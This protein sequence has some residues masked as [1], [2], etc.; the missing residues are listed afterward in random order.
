MNKNN[1]PKPIHIG[2]RQCD[3]FPSA[4]SKDYVKIDERSFN[5]LIQQMSEY[6][7]KV[8]FYNDDNPDK[9]DGH[10]EPFFKEIYDYETQSIKL[11]TLQKQM[12][13][14]TVPPHLSLLLSFL[15]LYQIEQNNLNRLTERHLEFY[16]KKVLGFTPRV[17]KV[18]NA[19]V[20]VSPVKN[21]SSVIIPKGT[22]FDAGKDSKGKTIL[23]ESTD[24][25]TINKAQV[26]DCYYSHRFDNGN[27]DIETL[28][29]Q[30]RTQD[31]VETNSNDT[32]QETIN[33]NFG[34]AIAISSFLE[35]KNQ[36]YINLGTLGEEI[37]L[38]FFTI[39]YT[40]LKGW[41]KIEDKPYA[42]IKEL[43][44][45]EREEFNALIDEI[46][47]DLN[48][49]N[50]H[51][52][53]TNS[54]IE[55]FL[56]HEDP[57]NDL[58][59]KISNAT[60]A[61]GNN[62]RERR[63]YFLKI[64]G[65]N[66]PMVPYNP[67]LHGEGYNS[68]NP[69]IR[70]LPAKG[71]DSRYID[72]QKNEIWRVLNIKHDSFNNIYLHEYESTDNITIENIYGMVNNVAGISPFGYI[73]QKNDYFLVKINI[74][75]REYY[76]NLKDDTYTIN[77]NIDGFLP[78]KTKYLSNTEYPVIQYTLK[79]DDRRIDKRMN[80]Y[81]NPIEETEGYD[82]CEECETVPTFDVT[83]ESASENDLH[84][85]GLIKGLKGL[86]SNV[87][88]NIIEKT[89]ITVL[90]NSVEANAMYIKSAFEAYGATVEI[91][92][93]SETTR[94]ETRRTAS[95]SKIV[96]SRTESSLNVKLTSVG[97]NKLDVIKKIKEIS[98]LGLKEAK[99][100]VENVPSI[101]KENVDIVTA[102]ALKKQLE[103]VGATV[104]ITDKPETAETKK[105]F[106]VFLISAG[107]NKL[108][109]IKL[110]REF[111]GL[112]LGE[113]KVLVE[114]NAPAIIKENVN[115]ATAEDIKK[116][117]EEAGATVEIIGNSE[118]DTT[119]ENLTGTS[120]NIILKSAGASSLQI[121]KLIKNLNGLPLKEAKNLVESAP[122]IIKENVDR[123]TAEDI[124]KQL[125][126]AGATVELV[127]NS[128]TDTTLEN[129][130]GSD[131]N[132]ILKSVGANKVQIIKIIR[133]FVDLGLKE[134]KELVESAPCTIMSDV[135][136]KTVVNIKKQLEDAGAIV[137]ITGY[138]ETVETKT[139][140]NV[141]LKS[142]NE[143]TI[144]LI[145]II[146]NYTGLEWEESIEAILKA[147][148]PI[149]TGVEE[150]IAMTIINEFENVGAIATKTEISPTIEDKPDPN[151]PYTT[152]ELKKA[153]SYN[154]NILIPT[155]KMELFTIAPWG[156]NKIDPQDGNKSDSKESDDAANYIFQD[157]K[158]PPLKYVEG[159]EESGVFIAI[160]GISQP[161]CLNIYFELGSYNIN[162]QIIKWSYLS[163]EN[164]WKEFSRKNVCKDGTE[165]FSKNGIVQLYLNKEV[166]RIKDD[167]PADKIW[168]YVSTQKTDGQKDTKLDDFLHKIKYIQT[169]AVE[170]SFSEESVGTLQNEICLPQGS[171]TK[172]I[173]SITGIKKVEQPF[174]GFVGIASET[175]DEFNC[176]V[177]EKLRHKGKAW[178]SWDYERILLERF[179][180]L[181]AVR[182]VPC[183]SDDSGTVKI[184]V[185][186]NV[187]L[188]PQ[189]DIRKPQI[190]AFTKN[191]IEHYLKTLCSPFVNIEI[192]NPSYKEVD[193]T[194]KITLRKEYHDHTYYLKLI[195]EAL[196][197]YLAPWRSN[198]MNISLTTHTPKNLEIQYFLEKLEY[199]DFIKEL[200]VD[201]K[202][203]NEE[204]LTII[205]YNSI[206]ITID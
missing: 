196:T 141:I 86:G 123:E 146:H 20:F 37:N 8:N 172:L 157:A 181:A 180:Q 149:S 2:T 197:N 22:L 170:V 175:T 60:L 96:E 95:N 114:N 148:Y 66:N 161:T 54:N 1:T 75:R 111:S 43:S 30:S 152:F 183:S 33:L 155:Q 187:S 203:L 191:E 150:E 160:S 56:S 185:F 82:Q 176:R 39:E 14:G 168:L 151:N 98:G 122:T 55:K 59:R 101:I 78:E 192:L 12:N 117:L 85:I 79:N 139:S 137:E 164:K 51:E 16:Y 194:G 162:K 5:D 136:K 6:A 73:C 171:I 46:I 130:T 198:P 195:E 65:V 90:E 25:V 88:T 29:I 49:I 4:L 167:I 116:Q 36:K 91:T 26:N 184:V 199:V 205:T 94:T 89:P 189:G 115:I 27:Y 206:E 165:N 113:A 50:G 44:E 18:G 124:K 76:S 28:Q 163:A 144:Q 24:E 153:I 110:I 35:A 158:F 62:R 68:N 109:V 52:E 48:C 34:F 105:C 202:S 45:D 23:F 119:L 21:T 61:D 179:P 118:T 108:N 106:N 70:F 84:V 131:F 47:P 97:A 74:P 177:S 134:A 17:G 154:S 174:D 77:L 112:G 120:F 104:E 201:S 178:T 67:K 40:S 80:N 190:D 7:K 41:E 87:A 19:V 147:P 186:P 32:I 140:F 200:S 11:R 100:L 182:C 169:Q 193:I 125:E 102:E 93:N 10:W 173:K 9:A 107:A 42:C 126:T 64:D 38:E 63:H 135:D 81:L 188:I 13:E 132:V 83:L 142:V 99:E 69:I 143:N 127:D 145:N 103:E 166:F 31:S 92:S 72:S 53:I 3:R 159:E 156:I 133:D 57:T 71:Q 129:L 15:K 204:E 138:S 121:V 58:I 128:E